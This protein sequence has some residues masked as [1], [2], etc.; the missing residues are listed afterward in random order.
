MVITLEFA[1]PDRIAGKAAC[2]RYNGPLRVEAGSLRIGP[3]VTTRMACPEPL[4]A[5]ES[6]FLAELE[7]ATR[8]S[9]DNSALLLHGAGSAPPSRFEPFTPP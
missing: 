6:R 3:L 1:D 8:L 9:R 7:A 5:A 4:M 2:N